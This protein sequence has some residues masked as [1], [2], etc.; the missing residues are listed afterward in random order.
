MK[1]SWIAPLTLLAPLCLANSVTASNFTS[2]KPP[3]QL[4]PQSTLIA[5]Y[6]WKQVTSST[7]KF[8]VNM[9]GKPTENTGKDEDGL[10][11]QS[12][13]LNSDSGFYSVSYL[14]FS[15]M[16]E[17]NSVQSQQLLDGVASKFLEKSGAKLLNNRSITLAGYP[18]QEFTFAINPKITGKGRVYLT[19]NK[20]YILM[21]V[22]P[23][24]ASFNTFLNSFRLLA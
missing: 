8:T 5:Q 1:L 20:L 2:P 17:I 9:P 13:T 6:S 19:N 21:A 14:D 23:E 11:T 18:G 15:Q 10:T 24:V 12:F 3:K 16:G 22:A 4:S 7:G